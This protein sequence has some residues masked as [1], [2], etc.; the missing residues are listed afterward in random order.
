MLWIKFMSAS[1]KINLRGMP[2]N[3]SDDQSTLLQ[4]MAWCC[5]A[6]SHY[7]TQCL[8]CSMSPHG[9]AIANKLRFCISVAPAFKVITHWGRVMQICVGKLTIIDSNNGLLPGRRQTIIWTN[10]GILLLGPLGTN[11]SEIL[12][13]IYTVSFKKMYLKRSSAK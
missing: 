9:V 5:Q 2:Q 12:I 8:P 3:T 6:T 4:V 13:K 7:L 10:A 1:Y 11:S